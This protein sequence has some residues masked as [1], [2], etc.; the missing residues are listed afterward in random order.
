MVRKNQNANPR[1][2]LHTYLVKQHQSISIFL[3]QRKSNKA[4]PPDLSRILVDQLSRLSS[5][6][7]IR[8]TSDLNYD[9][10]SSISS[11]DSI[12]FFVYA[13][14][15]ELI[16][17]L[18]SSSLIV[19]TDSVVYHLS[20]ALAVP[21]ISLFGN[22]SHL[23]YASDQVPGY[24]MDNSFG[25]PCYKGTKSSPFCGN[26]LCNPFCLNMTTL[27]PHKIVDRAV[28]LLSDG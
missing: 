1:T 9:L 3:P 13:H 20:S 15:Y 4:Y 12:S 28:M 11:K 14:W 26:S 24:H 16:T 23:F 27:L 19:T 10:E 5:V 17:Q 7:L 21:S 18:L 8:H 22:T 6:V 2:K 25:L